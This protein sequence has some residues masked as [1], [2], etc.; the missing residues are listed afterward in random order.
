METLVERAF[1]SE[2]EEEFSFSHA[3]LQKRMMQL[4]LRH[5]QNEYEVFLFV[6][7]QTTPISYT[8]DICLYPKRTIDLFDTSVA[9][10]SAPILAV[11]IVN[12]G[13]SSLELVHKAIAM[14]Q[15][16]VV[17]CLIVEPRANLVTVCTEKGRTSLHAGE[18]LH[19]PLFSDP[20]SLDEVFD[21]NS[22]TASNHTF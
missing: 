2:C 19:H 6:T 3:Q 22:S 14:I 12:H 10:N 21:T 7:F 20:I 9:E 13:Q 8:P 16:G 17:T 1:A 5:I 11:E 4:L 15:A 18:F